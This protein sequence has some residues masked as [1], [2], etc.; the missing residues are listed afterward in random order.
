MSEINEFNI[1]RCITC[2]KELLHEKSI[3]IEFEEIPYNR[4]KCIDCGTKTHLF[5]ILFLVYYYHSY[6]SKDLY[7]CKIKIIEPTLKYDIDTN[8]LLD[9]IKFYL[10]N[11]KYHHTVLLED[12]FYI[13]NVVLQDFSDL[14][15][16]VIIKVSG[17][18][19]LVSNVTNTLKDVNHL[20]VELN[21]IKD[22]IE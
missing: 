20:N 6:E 17:F 3:K 2:D 16:Y 5:N 11:L 10:E 4:F 22:Y 9:N 14:N 12:T 7:K 18:E 15:R 21:N 19:P 1:T 13:C 8:K